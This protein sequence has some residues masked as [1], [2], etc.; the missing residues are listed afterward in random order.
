MVRFV[1]WGFDFQKTVQPPTYRPGVS[2]V[3]A[4]S[5]YLFGSIEKGFIPATVV[6]D[7]PLFSTRCG[8]V[9][10][11]GSRKITTAVLKAR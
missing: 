10:S 11:H 5:L 7:A 3:R 6:N 2:P 4:S 8:P 1:H 9:D